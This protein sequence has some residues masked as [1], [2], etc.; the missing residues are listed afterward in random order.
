M[1][2]EEDVFD[3]E[4]GCLDLQGIDVGGIGGEEM[5]VEGIGVSGIE[6]RGLEGGAWDQNGLKFWRLQER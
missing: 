5:R 1:K 4:E 6:G 2:W 3:K